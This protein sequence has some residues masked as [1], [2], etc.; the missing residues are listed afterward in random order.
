MTWI[1]GWI[2]WMMDD[3]LDW[4]LDQLDVGKRELVSIP[5]VRSTSNQL[6]REFAEF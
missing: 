1:G 2:N 5:D 6:D 3:D 4:W